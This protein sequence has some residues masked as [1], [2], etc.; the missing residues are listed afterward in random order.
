MIDLKDIFYE[1]SSRNVLELIRKISDFHRAK[2]SLEYSKAIEIIQN[3]LKNSTLLTF[4]MNKTYNTW[5][6]PPSWNLKGVI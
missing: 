6:S 3:Y 1:F 2:G 5:Q 4:P